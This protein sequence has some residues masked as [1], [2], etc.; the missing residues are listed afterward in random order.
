[1]TPETRPPLAAVL[2]DM[3]GVVTDT[4]EAHFAAWKALFDPFLARR[5][6]PKPFTEA[7]Y[8]AHV[9]GR[10]RYEGVAAFLASRGIDLPRGEEDDRPDEE[11]ICGL[12]NRKNRLFNDWLAANRVHAFPG[13]LAFLDRIEGA[14]LAA[15]LF[16]SSRNADAVLRSAGIRQRFAAIVDGSVGAQLGLAGKPDPAYLIETA[17]RLGTEPAQ[18]AVIEDAVS[19]VAAGRAGGFGLVIGVDREGSAEDALIEAGADLVVADLAEID[20]RPGPVLAA[21]RLA[22]LPAA[23][24]RRAEIA[25]RIAGRRPVVFLD[26]DGTLAPIVE[27]PE[28]AVMGEGMREALG[29]LAARLPCAVVSGRDLDDVRGFVAHDGLYFAGSHGFDLAG[30]GGWRE[31]VEKGKA[32]LPVLAEAADA[33]EAALAGIAGARVE[34]KRFALAVHTRQVAEAEEERVAE[35]VRAVV[36]E[37]PRL[38]AS[39]GKKVWDVKPRTDWNKGYAVLALMK[40]LHLDGPDVLPLYLGDDTT[41]EDA[42]RALAGRGL[43]L[44][45]RDA[46]E[47]RRTAADYALDGTGDVEAFLRWLASQAEDAR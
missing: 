36:A 24:A 37:R 41:D 7:D 32:F 20:L 33:I 40:I 6:D 34:R 42:F 2:L 35:I 30:P 16:S 23:A 27:N 17:R 38:K 19:G 26:Y 18:A 9:D 22:D 43:G 8:R 3:D 47:D 12:G 4:A 5:G 25:A 10:P 46:G 29:A 15:G 1:V 31:V 44:V 28:D 39:R 21:R 11:T 45:V 13:S 14:G